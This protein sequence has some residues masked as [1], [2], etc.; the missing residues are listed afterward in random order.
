MIFEGAERQNREDVHN[1]RPNKSV[2]F[3]EY[4]EWRLM[5]KSRKIPAKTKN[6][7]RILLFGLALL[8]VGLCGSNAFALDLMG[9]P[10]AELE[11]GMARGG[12]EYSYG[13][14]E[15]KLIE[16]KGDQYRNGEFV[17]SGDVPS[18]TISD[19]KANKIYG[20]VGYG[21]F[22][23]CEGFLRIGMTGS[24]F[25]DSLFEQGE[26]FDGST[27]FTI[28]GGIKATFYEGFDLKLGAL[29]QANWAK[30][31]GKINTPD[32]SANDFAQIDLMEMQI[33]VGVSRMWSERLS[34]YGGPFV[35]FINGNF[36]LSLGRER[37]G[38][39]TEEYKWDINEGPIYGGYIGAQVKIAKNC[40]C[41]IE[42][43]NTSDT[44]TFGA[45]LMFRY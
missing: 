16:G 4:E 38:F 24:E 42:Y 9:P 8:I 10:V 29:I 45:N 12:I 3:K 27:D 5:M 32:L 40:Y 26:S 6:T 15:L 28:G 41:N 2:A 39:V 35:L 17:T 1:G 30:Y 44:D 19:F 34:I 43:Q 25:G 33:A 18:I 23:N 11:K 21:L 7:G 20:S 22:E 13:K 14:T 37:E 31:D 36:E